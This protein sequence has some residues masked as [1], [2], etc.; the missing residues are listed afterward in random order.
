MLQEGKNAGCRR[1]FT[2]DST[3]PVQETGDSGQVLTLPPNW[4][5][6]A[7]RT[8]F[9]GNYRPLLP[10]APKLFGTTRPATHGRRAS[11]KKFQNSKWDPLVPPMLATLSQGAVAQGGS[12]RIGDALLPGFCPAVNP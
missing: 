2:P 5:A 6:T 3:P 11:T 7:S 8:G 4:T 12:Q 10:G 1:S 9:G